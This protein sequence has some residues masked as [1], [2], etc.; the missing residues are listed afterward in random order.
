[1][2][3]LRAKMLES[4]LGWTQAGRKRQEFVQVVVEADEAVADAVVRAVA[5]AV[6]A[7]RSMGMAGIP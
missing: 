3:L 4:G 5:L 7:A 2:E 1:M 6:D